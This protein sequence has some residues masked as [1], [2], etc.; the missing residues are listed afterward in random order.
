MSISVLRRDI[1]EIICGTNYAFV[2]E[3]ESAFS[4]TEYKVMQSQTEDCFVRCM[5]MKYN[6]EPQL[7]YVTDGRYSLEY[8]VPS[9]SPENFIS[10][11][12]GIFK[13]VLAVKNNGFLSCCNLDMTPDKIYV[14]N[15]T[16]KV[17]LTYMP[18]SNRLHREYAEFEV[19]LREMLRRVINGNRNL[20]S[21][22]VYQL[23]DDL[24]SPGVR[25]EEIYHRMGK[26]ASSAPDFKEAPAS[27]DKVL[28]LTPEGAGKAITV[29]KN[30]FVLGKDAAKCDAVV[31]NKFVSGTHCSI[32]RSNGVF[33]V[34]DLNSTNRTRL[35]GEVLQPNKK[36]VIENN[37][38]LRLA[39]QNFTVEIR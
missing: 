13:T 38:A 11:V 39:N 6:G 25:I 7:Y 20:S 34:T 17:R 24:A 18:L 33:Y 2:L 36:T 14:D 30:R 1:E 12:A 21:S 23:L 37:S 15:S 3:D 8:L 19:Y 31:S 27:K 10:V 29:D 28:Y 9:L 16:F 26:F 5:R 4:P 35:N 32:E 22:K